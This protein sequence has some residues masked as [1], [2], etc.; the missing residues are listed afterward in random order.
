MMFKLP[1]LFAVVFLFSSFSVMANSPLKMDVFIETG[2]EKNV[3]APTG[4]K[5]SEFNVYRVDTLKIV[6]E[7]MSKGLSADPSEAKEQVLAMMNSDKFRNQYSIDMMEG[8]STINK[9]VR[10]GIEKVP[11]VVIND[12][13]VVYGVSP[14]EAVT[15]Y[16]QYIIRYGN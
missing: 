8:W 1:S 7:N 16:D 13:Y 6:E 14:K 2:A 10:L 4:R 9:V 11:A 12:K 15:I 5:V 3:F